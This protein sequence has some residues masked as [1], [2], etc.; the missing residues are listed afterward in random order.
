MSSGSIRDYSCT[1][2]LTHATAR[3]GTRDGPAAP[4]TTNLRAHTQ[5]LVGCCVCPIPSPTRTHTHA[6]SPLVS[7]HHS[8]HRSNTRPHFLFFTLRAITP[9]SPF[10]LFLS[11]LS[12]CSRLLQKFDEK[13]HIGNAMN[14]ASSSRPRC[15]AALSFGQCFCARGV[16]WGGERVGLIVK[17][18]RALAHCPTSASTIVRAIR[19]DV[20]DSCTSN[21]L[22]VFTQR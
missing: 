10:A 12:R 1:R 20:D 6:R 3:D 19:I 4:L 5:I 21:N 7:S 8:I 22:S 11:P 9:P 15:R 2:R 17:L 14:H 16:D 13:T 18:M